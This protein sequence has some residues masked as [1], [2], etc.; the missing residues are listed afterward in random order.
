[1]AKGPY[2]PTKD[3]DLDEWIDNYLVQL[4]VLG[5][6]L[7]IDPA[8]LGIVQNKALVY[9][10]KLNIVSTKTAEKQSAV[11]QKNLSKKDFTDTVRPLNQ[12]MKNHPNYTDENQGQLMRIVGPEQVVDPDEL[13]PVLKEGKDAGRPKIIWSKGHADA[14]S[15]YVDR[16]DG[17][18]Y[19]FLATDT[20]P[21]Y[22]D[23]FSIP[24]GQD[25]AVWDYKAIYILND[26]EVGQF[27]E[28]ITITVTNEV[29]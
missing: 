19:R 22:V 3:D 23:T 29:G 11:G 21:D 25:S 1:M 17:N 10:D 28:P 9:K 13:Q 7:G 20:E 27:S 4:V 15:I 24:A 8:E 6:A 5:V 18:N 26:E 14:L 12:R 2:L 16:R